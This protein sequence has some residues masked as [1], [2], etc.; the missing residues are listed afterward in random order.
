M[1]IMFAGMIP[2]G[3]KQKYLFGTFTLDLELKFPCHTF[4]AV[5]LAPSHSIRQ[6]M[7]IHPLRLKHTTPVAVLSVVVL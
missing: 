2:H 6:S 3:I 4:S 7:L 5:K 1:S